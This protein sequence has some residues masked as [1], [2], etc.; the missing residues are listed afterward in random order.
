M[1]GKG[2][3]FVENIEAKSQIQKNQGMLLRGVLLLLLGC[4]LVV[5]TSLCDMVGWFM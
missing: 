4:Y 2:G 5:I 3:K 1:K